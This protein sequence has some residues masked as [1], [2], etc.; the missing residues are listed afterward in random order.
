MEAANNLRLALETRRWSQRKLA[1]R[2]GVTEACVSRI[3]RGNRKSSEMRAR[4]A[5]VLNCDRLW[6]F[7]LGARR[8]AEPPKAAM[9]VR[10]PVKDLSA[11]GGSE[12]VETEEET[13]QAEGHSAGVKKEGK[14]DVLTTIIS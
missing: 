6:L 7:P 9:K 14:T 11:N 5:K 4:I 10:L 12:S 1:K 2:L 3:V 13:P 8:P